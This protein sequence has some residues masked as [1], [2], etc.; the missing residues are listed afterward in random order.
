[1]ELGDLLN[2]L[3]RFGLAILCFTLVGAAVGFGATVTTPKTYTATSRILLSGSDGATLQ[4]ASLTYAEVVS[5]PLVLRSVARGQSVSYTDLASRT[6]GY[7]RPG[8]AILDVAVQ[9]ADP[10]RAARLSIAVAQR[11]VTVVEDIAA[12][13]PRLTATRA[14]LIDPAAVPSRPSDPSMLQNV[15]GGGFAGLALGVALALIRY[16]RVRS[17]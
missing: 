10:R 7:G 1:V 6:Y 2:F 16:W 17:T 11:M 14:R 12:D 8:S 15:V 13:A 9:D 5:S 3:R 4:F